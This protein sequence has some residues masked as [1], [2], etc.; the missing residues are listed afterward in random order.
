LSKVSDE[1]KFDAELASLS[2]NYRDYYD[3]LIKLNKKEGFYDDTINVDSGTELQLLDP[4]RDDHNE[5]IRRQSDQRAMFKVQ[6]LLDTNGIDLKVDTELSDIKTGG[7]VLYDKNGKAFYV[8]H[9]RNAGMTNKDFEQPLLKRAADQVTAG[10]YNHPEAMFPHDEARNVSITDDTSVR[11][12]GLS[13]GWSRDTTPELYPGL[14][15]QADAVIAKYGKT[16]VHGVWY[17]NGGVKGHWLA[18]NKGIG[19]RMLDPMM[20]YTQAKYMREGFENPVDYVRTSG[21][22]AMGYGQA[23]NSIPILMDGPGKNVTITT[24]PQRKGTNYSDFMEHHSV[25]HDDEPLE[26]AAMQTQDP[27]FQ[28]FTPNADEFFHGVKDT[29]KSTPQGILTGAGAAAI[30]SGLDKDHKLGKQGDLL[31]TAGTN[32]IL[33]DIVKS[34]VSRSVVAVTGE[35]DLPTLAAYEASELVGDFVD[36]FTDTW[37]DRTA[38]KIVDSEA[39]ME[40]GVMGGV[41]TYSAQ[42][43]LLNAYRTWEAGSA[44]ITEAEEGI[45]LSD[46]AY[47]SVAAS[48]A[49]AAD[50]EVAG[51]IS[52]LPIPGARVVGGIIAAA[53]VLG[54]VFSGIFGNKKQD[55][56]L[57]PEERDKAYKKLEEHYKF[58]SE[59]Y[60]A[61]QK[62]QAFSPDKFGMIPEENVLTPNEIEF[63]KRMQPNYFKAANQ[64]MHA[65][66]D[67]EKRTLNIVKRLESKSKSDLGFYLR[68]G[69]LTDEEKSLLE[70]NAPDVLA[71]FKQESDKVAEKIYV[72]A[73]DLN[74]DLNEYE[75]FEER[76]YDGRINEDNIRA[77]MSKRLQR[78]ALKKGYENVGDYLKVKQGKTTD[79]LAHS[80]ELAKAQAGFKLVTAARGEGYSSTDAYLHHTQAD[81]QF[82]PQNNEFTR[83]NA[84]GLTMNQYEEYLKQRA[85]NKPLHQALDLAHAIDENKDEQASQAIQQYSD[86]FGPSVTGDLVSDY[87]NQ[88]L[89]NIDPTYDILT[90]A[91]KSNVI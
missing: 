22:S 45:E 84:L 28:K 15:D 75:Q 34:A 55:A 56:D 60:F 81:F 50:E 43:K 20:G 85:Q 2:Y 18:K 48:S 73:R 76:V 41:G 8:F 54:F 31:A 67:S 11:R 16:N 12:A 44:E 62:K 71:S 89:T 29:I 79:A 6:Q 51:E 63:M 69:D 68:Q 5:N 58:V 23:I 27:K 17:S 74:V 80:V 52:L 70:A 39:R 21:V 65:A 24:I 38:A 82:D 87:A 49:F 59:K 61:A 13:H 77:Q 14:G 64:S 47:D 86:E 37:K 40:S 25:H 53:G 88:Q 78:D 30:V 36:K 42:A 33:D 4:A 35:A 66:Y 7:L 72:Q 46:V 91:N 19:G 32:V 83:A 10:L 57:T 1:I 9:G 3:Q 90:P 26:N